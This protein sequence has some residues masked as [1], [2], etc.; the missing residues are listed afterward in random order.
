MTSTALPNLMGSNAIVSYR[1]RA[2]VARSHSAEGDIRQLLPQLV[3]EYSDMLL[4]YIR[5]FIPNAED[6]RDILQD[7]WLQILRKGHTYAGTGSLLGWIF[8]IARNNC[9]STLRRPD[10]RNTIQPVADLAC[11][12][13]RSAAPN[14]TPYLLAEQSELLA[15]VERAIARLAP[16]QRAVVRLRLVEGL[17]TREAATRMGCSTGTVK[18]SLFRAK[19]LLRTELS[20]WRS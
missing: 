6:A 15:D 5:K 3:A 16:R 1:G 14:P 13:W 2:R 10:H 17:S 7:V 18:G 8:S 4:A 11:Q 12:P 19:Q 20:H 9:L